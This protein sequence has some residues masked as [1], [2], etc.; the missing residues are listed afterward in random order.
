M[1]IYLF[2]FFSFS[3]G[4]GDCPTLICIEVVGRICAHKGNT[5]II[6]ALDRTYHSLPKGLLSIIT[7]PAK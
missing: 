7:A 3:G 4:G 2:S 6:T 1:L 5:I